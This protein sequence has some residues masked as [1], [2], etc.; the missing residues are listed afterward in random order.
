MTCSNCSI[1]V[2]RYLEKEG[3]QNVQVSLVS[4]DVL[5]DNDGDPASQSRLAAGIES[6]G[7]SVDTGESV[8]VRRHGLRFRNHLQ[9][10]IFCAVFTLPLCLHMLE[11]WLHTGWLANP[12][13]QLTLCIPVYVV[14][15][16]F[17]G[18]SAIRSIRNGVPNMNV[19]IALGSTA[20]FVY[21]LA[22]T[23]LGRGHAFLFYET[24]ALIITLVFLGN[25]LEDAAVDS[26]QRELKR[27]MRSQTVTAQMIAFNDKHEEIIFPVDNSQLR[28]GDL[29]LIRTGDQVPADCKILTGHASAD[30]SLLTGE[31]RPVAKNPKDL[32]LG[33]SLI[34]DGTVRAQVTAE[35][36]KSA[37]ANI[38]NLVKQAQ[39]E[40]PPAQVLADRISAIFIPLV[41]AIAAVSFIINLVVLQAF[42]PAFL[43]AIA[44]LVIACP[45]AMGLATPAALA[46][47]M[48]R[49]ARNGILFRHAKTLEAFK[50]IRQVVFDKTGTL[51]TGDF[52][53]S[54]LFSAIDESAF[55]RIVFSLEKNSSHPL[56]RSIQRHWQ[57]N[58]PVWWSAIEEIKG[59]GLKGT[60]K[61][62]D[63]FEIGSYKLAE[64]LT[65]DKTHTL[66]VLRNGQLIGW[67]DL[68]D[69]VRPEA[70]G[71]IAY[72]RAKKIKTV[73]L[74]GDRLEN[75]QPL[76]S[77]LG[78]DEVFA[79]HSPQQK[80]AR[81]SELAAQTPTAMV[82]DGINDAPALAKAT[83]GISIAEAS[84]IAL[85]TADVVL[86]NNGL[87]KLPLC[88]GLGRHTFLT[89]RQNLF[90]AF[91]YNII[92]LPVAALGWL[93]PAFGA[94][95]MG[96]SDVVLGV[97]SVRLYVKKVQ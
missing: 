83:I 2:A 28:G 85:Q 70:A 35:A 73:L 14:G 37:L 89:I 4:G 13:L 92:A 5:F 52:V 56:A 19:L 12:W 62:G 11:G 66:Y 47:G 88:L 81:I 46:V 90:W 43:R 25:Y 22:G 15:M 82:G 33:G 86:M 94:L 51:T 84:Q 18:R 72:L 44:V 8:P 10:F 1:A 68:A 91:I 42:T 55:K 64:E 24:A 38:V 93:T 30:E 48:G 21:S 27:L 3:K 75:C 40:K 87:S 29:V 67:V 65:T 61:N 31:S 54:C 7:Y 16:D 59:L 57:M 26:T 80:L 78:I 58:D 63:I 95:V 69:E 32:L 41:L 45:C 96:L 34:A 50:D 49:A 39:S 53:V 97:N 23:L 36:S 20:A 60:L 6:L 79:E 9:R 76:A 71:V 17:F 74:S 77:Q